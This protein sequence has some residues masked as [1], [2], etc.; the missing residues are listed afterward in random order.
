MSRLGYNTTRRFPFRRILVAATSL[1]AV[2]V[3]GLAVPAQAVPLPEPERNGTCQDLEFCYYFNS[4]NAGSISDFSG[5]FLTLGDYG[6]N[7]ATCYVFRTS[8]QSGYNQC[9]KNNAASVWNRTGKTINVYYNSN[10]G[11]SIAVQAISPGFKGNLNT[12][13]ANN[14]ASHRPQTAITPPPPKPPQAHI[15]GNHG[16]FGVLV[17]YKY[18]GVCGDDF[19]SQRV[20]VDLAFTSD[21]HPCLAPGEDYNAG[22]WGVETGMVRTITFE[23]YC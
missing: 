11:S 22:I 2:A 17:T 10:F 3:L 7:P 14:N 5:T 12:K 19:R 9:I 20:K 13:L 23:A 6:T 16:H 21:A 15:C 1:A 4:N 18:W 8:G